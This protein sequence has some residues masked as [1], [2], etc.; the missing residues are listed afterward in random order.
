MN[1]EHKSKYLR[2]KSQPKSKYIRTNSKPEEAEEEIT[3]E[4][5]NKKEYRKSVI[6][7]KRARE[8][9]LEEE[10]KAE[11]TESEEVITDADDNKYESPFNTDSETETIAEPEEI[12]PSLSE[13]AP[14]EE[15]LKEENESEAAGISHERPQKTFNADN[16]KMSKKATRM[17]ICII[18]LTVVALLLSLLK[19]HIPYTPSMLSVEFSTLPELIASIAYG[20]V[21]GVLVCFIKNFI[22]V[23]IHPTWAVSDFTNLLLDSTFVFIA[24]LIYSR[25][26]FSGDKKVVQPENSK[27]KD[28]RRR[29]IFKSSFIGAI[30]AVIPQFLITRFI[31]YPLLEML[32]RANRGITIEKLLA[33]YQANYNAIRNILPHAISRIMPEITNITRAIIVFNL[34]IT[35]VKLF[36]VTVVTALIYKYISPFLHYRKKTKNNEIKEK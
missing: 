30:I 10:R 4:E 13:D 11:E 34:P 21:F 18:F 9:M 36:I 33:D 23:I 8:L 24:G 12:Q 26:M 19:I 16:R 20:P 35:F 28:F 5:N 32:F 27:H 7:P 2:D 1:N 25:S 17:V 15:P 3:E 6:T 31:A 29:R 14:S 22:H